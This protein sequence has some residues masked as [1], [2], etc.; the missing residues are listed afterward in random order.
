[1]HQSFPL[2][3]L[4]IQGLNC[5]IFGADAAD[6]AN[7]NRS[8]LLAELTAGARRLGLAVDKRALAFSFGGRTQF[9]GD[10][11]L[12]GFLSNNWR[13]PCWTHEITL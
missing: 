11:D 3:H 7:G 8:R 5:A 13:G 10:P 6:H 2:A 12:V 9:Y 1:M 4:R